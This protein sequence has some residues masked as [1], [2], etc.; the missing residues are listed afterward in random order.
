MLRSSRIWMF[1]LDLPSISA[2][3]R[4]AWAF[5]SLERDP[6]SRGVVYRF[7]SNELVTLKSLRGE[8][9]VGHSSEAYVENIPPG[10]VADCHHADSTPSSRFFA[11]SLSFF[12]FLAAYTKKLRDIKNK[13]CDNKV[14]P[15]CTD[16]EASDNNDHKKIHSKLYY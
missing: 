7:S 9:F 13:P 6:L 14:L 3:M 16:L 2:A 5:C 10:V 1:E 15:P 11:S 12:S 8:V 4:S